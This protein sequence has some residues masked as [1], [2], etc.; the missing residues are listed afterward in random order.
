MKRRSWVFVLVMLVCIGI[1]AAAAAATATAY[2]E[3]EKDLSC[4]VGETLEIRKSDF[5]VF[6]ANSLINGKVKYKDADFEIYAYNYLFRGHADYSQEKTGDGDIIQYITPK[7]PGYYAAYAR[8]YYT[9]NDREVSVSSGF[10][11]LKVLDE[12]GNAPEPVPAAVEVFPV[13]S[14]VVGETLM[15][16]WAI[17]SGYY[18]FTDDIEVLKDGELLERW[19]YEETERDSF[20]VASAGTYTIRVTV[21]DGLGQTATDETEF[22]AEEPKS[23]KLISLTLRR[24]TLPD[25]G[26]LVGGIRWDLAYAGGIGTKITEVSLVNV[27]TDQ[28][29][30]LL[31]DVFC[32]SYTASVGSGTFRIRMNVKDDEGDHWIESNE[33]TTASIPA[34]ELTLP[35]DLK[36]I[37]ASAF[38]NVSAGTVYV[39]IGCKAIGEGAFRGLPLE[40]VFL[41]PSVKSIGEG[42]IPAGTVI[43]TRPGAWA[44]QWAAEHGYPV[45]YGS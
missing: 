19:N 31:S 28:E 1:C 40:A 4:K 20:T 39:N 32:P 10:F 36:R 43:Y 24:N 25:G 9:E 15:V 2:L 17:K 22:V 44:A 14:A 37:E 30:V 3:G 6:P 21:T 45:V 23:L 16:N 26:A 41:P 5:Q 12:D 38:E 35:N 8:A 7:V 13:S 29:F 11:M 27:D 33:V 42:A 18:P 34:W